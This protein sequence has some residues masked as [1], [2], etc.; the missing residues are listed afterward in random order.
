M[1]RVHLV[2]Y[3]P[4]IV[5]NCVKSSISSAIPD[6]TNTLTFQSGWLEREIGLSVA[7][8]RW[9]EPHNFC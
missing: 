6:V 5:M 9:P 2:S 1:L 7:K 3:F 8:E 4:K